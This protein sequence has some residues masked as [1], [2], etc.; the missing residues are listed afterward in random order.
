MMIDY[1]K[2]TSNSGLSTSHWGPS[3]W[4]FLFSCIMGGYPIKIDVKNKDHIKIKRHFKYLIESLGYTM[5]CI[6]CRD[7]YKQFYK[8]LPIDPFLTGRIKLM[9]WLYNIRD[10]VNKKLKAQEQ[11]CYNDEKKRLKK[12]YHNN[13]ISKNEY[14]NLVRSFKNKTFITKESPP[15]VEVLDKYEASRAVCSNKAK[16]CS[17]PDKR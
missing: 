14:Y 16:T 10:K 5:P 12:L 4:H 15:F 3:G 6:Y 11:Q 2:Y 9:E 13:E 7:S 1:S 8:E 17:L